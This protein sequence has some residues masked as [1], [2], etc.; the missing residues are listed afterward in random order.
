MNR[1]L[2]SFL[3]LFISQIS[4]AQSYFDDGLSAEWHRQR[5]D[6][7][8]ELMPA[9]SMAILFN[10]PVKNRS[11]DV[12]FIYHPNTDFY[13]L[14]GFREPNSALIIFSEKRMIDGM[15]TDEIIYVQPRDPRSEMWN[16]K[17]LGTEGVQEVLGFQTVFLF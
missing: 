5:R 13:Y 9:N 2:L 7:L 12:D 15:E 16:G 4:I 8:R 3:I 17:R 11:N 1:Y 10:N 14:T 6:A